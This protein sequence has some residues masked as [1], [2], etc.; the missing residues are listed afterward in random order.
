MGDADDLAAVR[1]RLRHL[2][3]MV[4]AMS[5]DLRHLVRAEAERSGREAEA[6]KRQHENHDDR[7]QVWVRALIPTGVLTGIYLA[8]WRLVFG[9]E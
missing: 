2:D 9:S 4:A 7:W 3:K 1:E 5:D 6:A 8:I